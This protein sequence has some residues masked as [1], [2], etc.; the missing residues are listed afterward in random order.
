MAISQPDK[1]PKRPRDAP[2]IEPVIIGRHR[3]NDGDLGHF[4]GLQPD[5][6]DL[7]PAPGAHADAAKELDPK[8]QQH[9]ERIG[10]PCHRAPE[11][12]RHE[13]DG[14]HQRQPQ[15]EAAHLRLGPGRQRAAG[16]RVEHQEPHRRHRGKQHHQRPVDMQYLGKAGWRAPDVVFEIAHACFPRRPSCAAALRAVRA[17]RADTLAHLAQHRLDPVALG[18]RIGLDGGQPPLSAASMMSRAMGAATVEPPP[19]CSTTTLSA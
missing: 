13:G 10:Q 9:R 4:R 15:P 19:P 3:Q 17:G 16:D 1:H 18:L 14:E 11:P 2:E 7:Q 8:Q 5:R 12:Q 6:A